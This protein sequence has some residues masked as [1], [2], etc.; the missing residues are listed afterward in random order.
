MVRDPQIRVGWEMVGRF[1]G[2]LVGMFFFVGFA[3]FT[4][5]AVGIF[6]GVCC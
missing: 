6:L 4:Y 1:L 2:G 3:G 5:Y